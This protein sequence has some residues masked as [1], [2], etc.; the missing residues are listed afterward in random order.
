[1]ILISEFMC[2]AYSMSLKDCLYFFLQRQV[3]REY[4]LESEPL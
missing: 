1:M 2:Q 4:E 3:F